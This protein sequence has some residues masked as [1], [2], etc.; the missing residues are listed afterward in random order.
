VLAGA[1]A[2][3]KMRNVLLENCSTTGRGGAVCVRDG[4]QLDAEFV[5]VL[6]CSAELEGGGVYLGRKSR[7]QVRDSVFHDCTAG[8]GGAF[9]LLNATLSAQRVSMHLN[10]AV[11]SRG[12]ALNGVEGSRISV[13]DHSRFENNSSPDYGGMCNVEDVSSLKLSDGV[14]VSGSTSG[15]GGGICGTK[16]STVE[17]EGDVVGRENVAA[18]EGGF[19][20]VSDQSVLYARGRILVLDNHAEKSGGGIRAYKSVLELVGTEI[21]GNT[22]VSWGGG[23]AQSGV[24]E[25]MFDSVQIDGNM[26]KGESGASIWSGVTLVVKGNSSISNNT[27]MVGPKGSTTYGGGL[28][29]TFGVACFLLDNV[30]ISHNVNGAKGWNKGLGGGVYV[31]SDSSLHVTDKVVISHNFASNTGGGIMSST[32]GMIVLANESRVTNNYVVRK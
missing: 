6:G 24:G 32:R 19:I 10:T 12:G 28:G 11:T 22:A 4:G 5:S 8:D 31:Q 25:A 2:S 13:R 15:R 18:V 29:V 16:G 30:T 20:Y 17:L 7:A 23:V 3:L 1:G 21:R 9:H 26:A 27:V 14:T